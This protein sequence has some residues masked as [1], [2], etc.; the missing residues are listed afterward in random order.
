MRAGV[1]SRALLLALAIAAFWPVWTWYAARVAASPEE[2]WGLISL[3][4]ALVFLLGDRDTTSASPARLAVPAALAAFYAASY[5]SLPA[6]GR[7]CI[8]VAAVASTAYALFGG[9]RPPV[10]AWGLLPLS[11]PVVATLQFYLGFPL[12]VVTATAA[13]AMIQSTGFAVV[14]DGT[15]LDWH[16]TPVLVD[17]PCSGVRMLWAGLYLALALASAYR[18]SAWRTALAATAAV[19]AV[20][21]GN[22]MRAAALFYV[23]TGVVDAAAWAHQGVGVVA[24]AMVAVAIVAGVRRIRPEVACPESLAS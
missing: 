1:T 20:L 10:A 17:A 5:S 8:A 19:V 13:S 23:E 11:L 18:L 15:V 24:F 16:G 2:V 21:G 6:L 7:A 9:A 14:R 3:A 22:A 12:R 4:T